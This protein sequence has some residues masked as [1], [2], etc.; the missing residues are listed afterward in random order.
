MFFNNV[1]EKNTIDSK[2]GQEYVSLQKE[3]ESL[4]EKKK[5]K[6]FNLLDALKT[7]DEEEVQTAVA[8]LQAADQLSKNTKSKALEVIKEADPEADTND[9]NYIFLTYVINFLP[10]GLVGLLIAVILSASM[11]STSGELN[12]LASTTL[13]D[14]YKRLI[15]KNASD[16]H[17]LVASKWMTVGWGIYAILFAMYANR[18]GTLIEAV[19]RLGSLVYGTILGIFLVA[20]YFKHL[21]WRNTLIAAATSEI[22]ILSLWLFS[23]VPFLWYNVIGAISVILFS[24]IL[25]KIHPENSNS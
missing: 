7:N 13:I 24:A 23:D 17:Y 3:Y 9:T 11:S 8:E 16:H 20:I 22:I 19:N 21:G 18:L 15:N 1:I 10:A 12:A 4:H 2:V 6:A 25:E 14:V 5:E